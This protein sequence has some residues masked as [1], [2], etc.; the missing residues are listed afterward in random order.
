MTRL[1][2]DWEESINWK[3]LR[4]Y[5]I[6]KLTKYMKSRGMD[7]LMVTKLDAIRYITSFRP[8][9]S[10]LFHGNRYV[11]ILK[12]DGHIK[13][14]VAS[15]DYDRA[16]EGMPWID[17]VEPF[18]FLMIEGVANI[19]S[20]LKVLGLDEAC[21][22]LDLIQFNVYER[23]IKEL[24]KVHFVDGLNATYFA[25]AVKSPE[26]ITLLRQ[27]AEVVDAGMIGALN[28]I[29]EGI[30]EYKIAQAS[31]SAIMSKGVEDIT[32]IPLVGS[33]ENIWL[34]YRF[35][36][37]KIIHR[38]DMVYIDCGCAVVNGYHGDI[39]RIAMVGDPTAEQ[40]KAYQAIYK[41]LQ[42]GISMLHPGILIQD[43]VEAVDEV[44]QQSG[45]GK[46]AYFGILGHGIGTDLHTAPT[47][48]EKAIKNIQRELD[49]IEENMLVALEPGLL[50]PDIG[51]GHLEDMVLVTK[52]GPETLTKTKFNLE[53]LK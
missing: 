25:Q 23:L 43:I 41:M 42:T 8:V 33:G 46:Y 19:V 9:Y 31:I 15:G 16:K 20:S 26:E 44:A 39:A 13:F 5:R 47:I 34:G 3:A 17:D 27:A 29:H 28:A 45:Y 50:I 40:R 36:T 32:Y 14:L 52:K 2:V 18:P 53:M 24:P 21:I 10:W 6:K 11:V 22:G 37:D 12:S 38:G 51:G 4:T 30:T 35:P 48:G 49:T 7:A 1:S